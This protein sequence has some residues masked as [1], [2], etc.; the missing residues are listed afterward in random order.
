MPYP[1]SVNMQSN[2]Y[3]SLENIF[4]NISYWME[5]ENSLRSRIHQHE[6]NFLEELMYIQNH[7]LYEELHYIH[8]HHSKDSTNS[9]STG[10]HMNSVP[11]SVS[12]RNQFFDTLTPLDSFYFDW[13]HLSLYPPSPPH[14]SFPWTNPPPFET[15]PIPPPPI[16]ESHITIK[17]HL[18]HFNQPYS[19]T[20][21][22]YNTFNAGRVDPSQITP[23]E[24]INSQLPGSKTVNFKPTVQPD[25]ET[26]FINPENSGFT[27]P[28]TS[29]MSETDLQIGYI[30][31][32]TYPNMNQA[33]S[34]SIWDSTND[35][36]IQMYPVHHNGYEAFQPLTLVN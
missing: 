14:T 6:E 23:Y 4:E 26:Y 13:Q 10:L 24:L 25:M 32:N 31:V 21:A 3:D 20:D 11:D 17:I 29:D 12:S 34:G 1:H 18:P 22:F 7:E 27:M 2:P 15:I 33:P 5:T 8:S 30:P 28:L 16:M 36:Q 35:S 9:I 19:Y